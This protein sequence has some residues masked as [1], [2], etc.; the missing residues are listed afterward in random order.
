MAVPA[1][2]LRIEKGTFF[3]AT[4][5]LTG[6]DGDAAALSNYTAAAKIKKFPGATTSTSFSTEIT[7]STGEIKITMADSVTAELSA[8]RSYYDV[9][10]QE[11][12]SLKKTKVFEG[13]VMVVESISA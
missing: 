8:G 3:E 13:T 9:V 5:T 10:I 11:T 12:A 7:G 6:T 4:F 1:V 2:N